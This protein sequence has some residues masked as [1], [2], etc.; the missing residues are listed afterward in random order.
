M[1]QETRKQGYPQNACATGDLLRQ[2]DSSTGRACR[3]DG[4]CKPGLAARD[5]EARAGGTDESALG[6]TFRPR[7]PQAQ[8]SGV[9]LTRGRRVVPRPRTGT[10]EDQ[11]RFIE[12]CI[13]IAFEPSH[14][15][16][17]RVAAGDPSNCRRDRVWVT[18][19]RAY[20]EAEGPSVDVSGASGT[21]AC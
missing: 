20:D 7:G 12:V 21:R 3:G 1:F 11:D 9:G 13:I 6:T 19:H 10:K 2:D 4:P 14:C 16:I 17:R 8:I 15:F 18:H 5:N